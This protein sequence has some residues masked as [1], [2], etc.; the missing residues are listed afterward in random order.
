MRRDARRARRGV[1]G[2]ARRHPGDRV[3]DGRGG[4]RLA[5][6]ARASAGE[7]CRDFVAWAEGR[8]EARPSDLF[9]SLGGQS[10]VLGRSGLR[11]RGG[12][13]ADLD[14]R[15][16]ALL[17]LTFLAGSGRAEDDLP[18]R[19]PA[20]AGGPNDATK[21][22]QDPERRGRGERGQPAARLRGVESH[23]EG[24]APDSAGAVDRVLGCELSA[25]RMIPY[26]R[27]TPV[28]EEMVAKLRSSCE[29]IGIVEPSGDVEVHGIVL[30]CRPAQ[31]RDSL[32]RAD[33]FGARVRAAPGGQSRRAAALDNQAVE[34][35]EA[36]EAKRLWRLVHYRTGF[37]VQIIVDTGSAPGEAP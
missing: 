21:L 13:A 11:P 30:R 31:R 7:V 5:C 17:R 25:D 28:A 9:D 3:D 2:A 26:W 37:S 32:R 23:P 20:T 16:V 14:R 27:A 22:R 12:G 29:A 34:G 33:R 24:G 10:A 35:V 18:E 36:S 15:V 4:R 6:A 19:A 8:A 1:A